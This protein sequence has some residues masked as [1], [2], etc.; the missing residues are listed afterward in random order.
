MQISAICQQYQAGEENGV[1]G[2]LER[3]RAKHWT[4]WHHFSRSGCNLFKKSRTALVE[5]FSFRGSQFHQPTCFW[6]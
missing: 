6:K 5:N 1:G 4:N 2:Q 3:L